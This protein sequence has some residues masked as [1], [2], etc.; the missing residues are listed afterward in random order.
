ME[1]GE[2]NKSKE[3]QK[4]LEEAIETLDNKLKSMTL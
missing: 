3:T 4:R 1:S 2:L